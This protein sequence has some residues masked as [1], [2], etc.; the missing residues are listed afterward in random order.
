MKGSHYP[1]ALV[2]GDQSLSEALSLGKVPIY[3]SL[4]HKYRVIP[5]LAESMSKI[6]PSLAV[7]INRLQLSHTL[8]QQREIS[9]KE[10][11]QSLK[12]TISTLMSRTDD[13]QNKIIQVTK[14]NNLADVILNKLGE[15]EAHD[16]Q[17]LSH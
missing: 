13:F 2:T 14:E 9:P 11:A 16:A 4:S 8:K 15:S 12:E 1:F 3:Q 6:D 10:V 7:T 17:S 5:G